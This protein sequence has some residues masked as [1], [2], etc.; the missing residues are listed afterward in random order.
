MKKLIVLLLI[1]FL[2]GCG[3]DEEPM[4][5]EQAV[6]DAP[7]VTEPEVTEPQQPSQ[8]KPLGNV[9]IQSEFELTDL[10]YS[11]PFESEEAIRHTLKFEA[12]EPIRVTVY[13]ERRWK[14]F[15]ID[16]VH[17]SSKMSTNDVE[18]CCK[19]TGNYVFDV[20]MEEGGN[21]Y[22]VVDDSGLSNEA[23]RPSSITVTLTQESALGG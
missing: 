16:G 15:D 3:S 19:D 9:V 13:D 2:L 6:P 1:V 8:P 18:G 21:Y 20:N 23:P 10:P 17:T 12:D 7:E 4:Q 22:I 5:E 11:I 14:K